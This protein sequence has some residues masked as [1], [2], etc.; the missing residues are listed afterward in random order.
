MRDQ[1]AERPAGCG[2]HGALGEELPHQA[3]P[4]GAEG[5]T[6][7]QLLLACG[8]AR[9]HEARN[10]RARNHQDDPDH[11]HDRYQAHSDS[12]RDRVGHRHQVGA[13]PG[14]RVGIQLFEPPRDRRHVVPR[15]L[16]RDAAAEPTHGAEEPA[17]AIRI[18]AQRLE[19]FLG[20]TV[21]RK[22]RGHHT[23]DGVRPFI[24]ANRLTDG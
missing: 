6:K 22:T 4:S 21:K 13:D 19:E 7:R 2:D 10:V 20:F 18:D 24:D 3:K 15:L 11:R 8:A 17:V 5:G 14:M 9:E 12:S 1:Q 16:D 23:D